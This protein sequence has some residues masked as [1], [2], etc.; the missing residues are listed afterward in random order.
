M[1]KVLKA[2]GAIVG[3]VAIVASGGLGAA[4][5]GAVTTAVGVSAATLTLIGA[6]L[7]IGASLLAKKPSA[8]TN[9]NEPLNRLRANIDVRT[10][11][12]TAVGRTALNTDI[13]DEEFTD[14][15]GYF[16]RF[17]V[18]A[19]HKV[20]SIDEIWFDDKLAW[21]LSSGVTSDFAGYLD[22]TPVTEGSAS[23]AIYVS[24]RMGSSRRYTGLAY[25][26]LRYK[27]TGNTTKTSSPF[28]QSITTRITIR[29]RGALVYDPRR[30]STV[31]G[32]SGSLR[33][34]NQTTW[35][36]NDDASRNPALL[37]L[38][39]L[40]GW[41]INGKL[42]VGKGIPKD[43]IDLASFAVA[44]NICDELVTNIGG[45]IE[46]RY[47]CDGV[48]SEADSPTSVIDMLKASMNADLDDVD[49]KLRL[50]VFHND[51]SNVVYAFTEDDVLGEFEWS[52]GQALDQTFNIVRGTYTDASDN[53]LYQP[54]DYPAAEQISEDGIDR[55]DTY[56]LPMVQSA[57]QA[58]RLATLR[59]LRNNFAGTFSATF[60]ATAWAVQ[61]NSI[62]TLTFP[63]RGFVNKLFRV[64]EIEHRTDG[65]VPL[66]LREEEAPIY[67]APTLQAPVSGV[68]PTEYDPAL[69][70]IVAGIEDAGATATWSNITGAGKPED[71]ATD[72][73]DIGVNLRL[74]TRVPT[75][76]E[77]ITADGV[78]AG[79]YG[80]TAWGTY[81]GRDPGYLDLLARPGANALFNGSLRLNW[82]GW[83]SGGLALSR[84]WRGNIVE[85]PSGTGGTFVAASQRPINAGNGV[86][87]TLSA[88]FTGSATVN[89]LMFVDIQWR[90]GGNGA[91]LGYSSGT[92]NNCILINE[93]SNKKLAVQSMTAPSATDGSGFVRGYVRIVSISDVAY[94]GG[95]RWVEQIKVETGTSATPFSDEATDSALYADGTLIDGLKP[96]EFGANKT[97]T[98][99]AAGFVGAGAGAYANNLADLDAVA[100]AQLAAAYSGST[101]TA[102]YGETL[103]RRIAVGGGLSLTGQVS[104]A[105]GGSSSGTVKARVEVSPFGEGTWSTVDT[106]SGIS[107][108]PSEPGATSVT[109]TF[110]NTTG[111][112]KMF[113]FRVAVVRT[114]S[115]AGGAVIASETYLT[116]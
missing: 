33:A 37:L 63:A 14:N 103:K 21:S 78:A 44:A 81:S 46:P 32:G 25:V 42:V 87:V 35:A 104:V 62:V 26:Y 99:I 75:Q 106:G 61:K 105:A 7:S 109:C 20:Q 66:V 90:N 13:R 55:I 115:G 92:S 59:L 11:R 93:T 72:G 5:A 85:P 4:V 107:V 108:T 57:G 76:A 16:H 38:F 56:N 95:T 10:P 96:Q 27:L 41:Q 6:G 18:V 82:A 79:Y 22:V 47:R 65:T 83:S 28:A 101:Q 36:W 112:E 116:G 67:G 71:N 48:W 64:A 91:H 102:G 50:T 31:V 24:P 58:Q 40:L 68:S 29:G 77:L 73:A 9:S 114:P 45:G 12:K 39:Y 74:P 8:P 2:V 110:T 49:G 80:Q 3:V 84:D 53:S 60:Q 88:V 111:V 52:P 1:S 69:D 100:A 94:T 51:L 43:R 97:E 70:P 113:E 89:A 98:R 23:N 30:D 54:V 17:I 15:Q 86:P 19:S 34:D